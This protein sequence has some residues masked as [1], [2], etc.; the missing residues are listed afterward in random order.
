MIKGAL[1]FNKDKKIKYLY[2]ILFLIR[3]LM[4]R[5]YLQKKYLQKLLRVLDLIQS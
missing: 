2:F 1:H 5:H 3:C 4:F